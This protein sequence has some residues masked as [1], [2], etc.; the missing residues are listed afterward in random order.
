METSTV[1][2]DE[3]AHKET[4]DILPSDVIGNILAFCSGE[5]LLRLYETCRTFRDILN[6][7]VG[8]LRLG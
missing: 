2:G 1:K 7:E 3:L 4:F 6:S 8:G 5:S